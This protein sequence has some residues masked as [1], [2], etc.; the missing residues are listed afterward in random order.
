MAHRPM[1]IADAGSMYVAKM[2]G[3][4]LAYDLF[5][6][7]VGELA[8]LADETAPHPIYTRGFILHEDNRVPDLISRVYAHKNAAR[9]LLVK[10]RQDYIANEEKILATIDSPMDEALEAIG[11]TGDTLT[12]IVS[13][14]IETGMGISEAA[15]IAARANRLAGHYA[16][17]TPATQLIEIIGQ[18]PRALDE[19]L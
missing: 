19:I 8:F 10:G 11:G 13:V 14:L 2:G 1:L 16:E 6:P 5:T 3:K 15:S 7:D 17:P 12:G 9:Y 18:I 4:S